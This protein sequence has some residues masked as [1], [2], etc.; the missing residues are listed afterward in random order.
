MVV[1]AAAGGGVR[2]SYWTAAILGKIQ[3]MYGD[4]GKHVFAISAVSGTEPSAS[5]A[6][7]GLDLRGISWRTQISNAG[8]SPETN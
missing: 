7:A 3:D 8:L 4:F 6:E 1:V 2:A 5:L